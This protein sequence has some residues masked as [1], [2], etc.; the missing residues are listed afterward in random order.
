MRPGVGGTLLD[1][2]GGTAVGA[3]D[4][5]R[6][7]NSRECGVHN[8]IGALIRARADKQQIRR[9]RVGNRKRDA[10]LI[11]VVWKLFVFAYCNDKMV[12]LTSTMLLMLDTMGNAPELVNSTLA[13]ALSVAVQLAL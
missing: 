1:Y 12:L 13:V 9:G 8:L 11:S 3:E 2:K 5:Q 6:T 4:H 10:G 7:A